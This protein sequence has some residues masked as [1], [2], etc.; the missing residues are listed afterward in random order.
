MLGM[1]DDIQYLARRLLNQD[2]IDKI[3]RARERLLLKSDRSSRRRS[4]GRRSRIA[5]K[6]GI[7]S[8]AM[9]LRHG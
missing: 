1:L 8:G 2:I 5:A 7:R 3:G 9:F 4:L 6:G